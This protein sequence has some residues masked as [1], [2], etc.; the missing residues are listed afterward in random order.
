M[1]SIE[2][3]DF[4]KLIGATGVAATLPLDASFGADWPSRPITAVVSTSQGGGVDTVMRNLEPLLEERL[5]GATIN[6]TNKT[7][8]T[9]SIATKYVFSQPSDGNWWLSCPGFNRGLR[10]LDLIDTVEYTDWQFYGCDTSI[11]SV[12][13]LPDS[14]IKDMDDLIKRGKDNPGELRMSTNGPGGTWHLAALLFMRDTG[15]DYRIVPYKGGKPATTACLE[16]EVDVAISGTH[17][18]LPFVKSGQLRNLCVMSGKT[19]DAQGQSLQPITNWV[20]TLEP[21]T[22][23]G[24]GQSIALKRDVDPAILK[25]LAQAWLDSVNSDTF[26]E[27]DAKQ[28]RFPDPVVLEDADRRAALWD[29][30]ASNLLVEQ[31]LAK[32]TLAEV[33][34]PTIQDFDSWWPPKGYKPIG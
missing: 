30:V 12:G 34:L 14:P 32:K 29:C 24:G 31:G 19:L 13:V 7:G 27:I 26:Q 9:S 28:P 15:T 8:G 33:N 3:R 5:G 21:L 17:E 1:N 6:V 11:A 25:K 18:Q 16:G 23:I 20:P 4:L 2:R 10:V 22:P